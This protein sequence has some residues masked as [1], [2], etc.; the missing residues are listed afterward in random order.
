MNEIA[1]SNW[2]PK[3]GSL[4]PRAEIHGS[5]FEGRRVQ[6]NSDSG[7]TSCLEGN[8][9]LVFMNED[10]SGSPY[11]KLDQFLDA[12]ETVAEYTGQ[13]PRGD[14]TWTRGN[15]VLRE[16]DAND[17]PIHLFHRLSSTADY[18]YKGIVEV[19]D[20]RL[21]RD[22][23]VDGNERDAIVFTLK[24]KSENRELQD[25][26]GRSDVPKRFKKRTPRDSP[27][28]NIPGTKAGYA[29]QKEH[30]LEDEFCV[31]LERKEHQVEVVDG[32]WLER[33]DPDVI[34]LTDR[35]V[36]EA[37]GSAERRKVREAIGQVLD[38][39]DTLRRHG[40]QFRP[41][42]LFPSRPDD[43]RVALIKS[44]GIV[45]IYRDQSVGFRYEPELDQSNS[46]L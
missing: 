8:E 15:K 2:P 5:I 28:H 21:D 12:A 23:D 17:K 20:W 3:V 44:L 13:G 32:A 45:L 35:L 7:I 46:V 25:T 27:G 16:A 9:V 40:E 18:R 36:I 26:A 37:K 4:M 6:G 43:H 1:S 10:E 31:W 33:Q 14:Q 39:V 41:A 42:V 24:V 34:D 29:E 11:T 38:Y 30:A 19:A 22:I